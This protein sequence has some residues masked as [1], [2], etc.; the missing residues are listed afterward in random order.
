MFVFSFQKLKMEVLI[1]QHLLDAL[2]S[3]ALRLLE[4]GHIVDR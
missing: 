1:G 2:F 4:K 3:E